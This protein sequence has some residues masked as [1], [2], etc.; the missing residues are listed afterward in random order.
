MK[1][2]DTNAHL[3]LT[4]FWC[5]QATN[6]ARTLPGAQ[7]SRS[8]KLSGAFQELGPCPARLPFFI[9]SEHLLAPPTAGICL[10]EACDGL[11]GPPCPAA[12]P[13]LRPPPGTAPLSAET[14]VSSSCDNRTHTLAHLIQGLTSLVCGPGAGLGQDC[15][16]V[17]AFQTVN[18]CHD[19]PPRGPPGKRVLRRAVS[20]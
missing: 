13:S 14:S 15:R 18:S 20:S 5:P 9:P 19:L 10:P 2:M 17:S 7:P 4:P 8:R 3:T 6:P 12:P 1:H 16:S 11:R